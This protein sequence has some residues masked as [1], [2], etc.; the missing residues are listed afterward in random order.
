MTGPTLD[1]AIETLRRALAA[2]LAPH[3]LIVRPRAM[4]RYTTGFRFGHGDAAAVVLPATALALWRAV[5]ICARHGAAIIVQA[6]NTGLTGGSTPA[7]DDYGRPVV[8][9]NTL[10]LDAIRVLGDGAQVLCCAGATLHR[11]EAALAPLG[12]DPHSVIGSSCIGASV[13][14]GV[15]NNSGGALVERGPAYTEAALY[16]RIGADGSVALVNHLGIDLGSEP[17]TMLARLDRGDH[18]LAA[19]DDPCRAVSDPGYAA[20]VRD[21]D[22]GT[23]ARYNADP[24]RLNE[25]SGCAGK[26][27]VFAVRLATYPRPRE[28][29]V[30]YIGANDPAALAELRR[31]MLSGGMRLPIAAEYLHRG[32]F[33]IADRYGKDG[34]V[35]LGLLGV[36]RIRHL[37]R[38]KQAMAQLLSRFGLGAGAEE[39]LLQRLARWLPD[40]LPARLREWR[41]RYEHHLMIRCG[42]E[43]VAQ[44]RAWLQANWGEAAGGWFECDAREG[45]AAFRHR[46]VAAGAAIRYRAVHHRQV[47]DIVALDIALRRDDR[48]WFETLPPHLDDAI[49]ARLYYGHFFC[50]VFHQDYL[51]EKGHDPMAVEHA[52]W[53]LLDARGAEYPAEHNVGHLYHAKPALAGFYRELD[54]SNALNP[55]LG[56]LSKAANYAGD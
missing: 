8:V 15:C 5:N 50:H 52:M 10:R 16:A 32:A 30:F 21:V 17:E 38:L 39:R 18:S 25:A 46:F 55:G 22:A 1:P 56:G 7:G 45:E 27:V 42:D 9:I 47:A 26:L 40:H 13:V 51:I 14:G 33:D 28:T 20:I 49:M 3:E 53:K 41:D 19:V 4:T 2:A 44:T 11:L 34:Y 31:G 29:G 43:G 37:F 23:P 54:P 48:A 36:N 6:A 24:R 12:R 35:A